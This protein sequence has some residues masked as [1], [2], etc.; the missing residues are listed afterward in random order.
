MTPVTIGDQKFIKD[1]DKGWIDSKTKQ[2]ADKGLIRLLDS[3][4]VNEP[5]LKRLRSK[6]DRTVEP[7][8][9]GGQK[10][11]YDVNQGWIDEKT[12]IP[13]PPSLQR[14]LSNLVPRFGK[15]DSSDID[16][17]AGFGIVG[18]AGLQQ[19][20]TTTLDFSTL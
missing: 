12:K 14:T 15:N 20:K 2:P 11:V 6:I 9:F 17:T 19:T 10:F 5:A 4:V 8:S 16:L 13:V 3:L 1:I 18:S 7:V